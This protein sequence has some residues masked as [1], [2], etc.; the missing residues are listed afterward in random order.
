MNKFVKMKLD[1][2]I[3]GVKNLVLNTDS[4]EQKI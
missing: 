4:L 2:K 3:E 1:L